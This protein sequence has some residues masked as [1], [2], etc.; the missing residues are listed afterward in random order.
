MGKKKKKLKLDPSSQAAKAAYNLYVKKTML[1]G[2]EPME[3]NQWL[4]SQGFK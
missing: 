2:G 4:A 1:A 3:F